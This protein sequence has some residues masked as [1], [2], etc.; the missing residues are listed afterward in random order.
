MTATTRRSRYLHLLLSALLLG[1]LPWQT[2]AATAAPPRPTVTISPHGKTVRAGKSYKF[3]IR[4]RGCRS[5]DVELRMLAGAVGDLD[6]DGE[7]EAPRHVRR[8]HEFYI[9][10]R[11]KRLRHVFDRA[12]VIV[13]PRDMARPDDPV[14]KSFRA[15]KTRI[16]AGETVE[17]SWRAEKA[18]HV[19]IEPGVG[20]RRTRGKITVRPLVTTQYTCTAV[21]QHWH[22]VSRIRI[23]VQPRG[24]H[25][26]LK[27]RVKLLTVTPGRTT[28]GQSVTIQWETERATAIRLVSELGEQYVR[29]SGT[30]RFTPTTGGEHTIMLE[31]SNPLGVDRKEV[32]LRVRDLSR[33]MPK[34]LVFTAAP[35]AVAA[36]APATLTYQTANARRVY[37]VGPRR[38]RLLAGTSGRVLVYPTQS[39]AYKLEAV[40]R[41]GK[42]EATVA[43]RV[44]VAPPP[45]P[46]RIQ[47]FQADPELLFGPGPV[48]LTWRVHGA[49]S[50]SV[51]GL[52]SPNVAAGGMTVQLWRTQEFVLRATNRAG[53]SEAKVRVEL[54][55][56]QPPRIV[57]FSASPQRLH[58]GEK[59]L[60]AWQ[61]TDATRV[62][63][64]G[65]DGRPEQVNPVG[66]REVEFAAHGDHSFRLVATGV[67]GQVEATADVN[68]RPS[69]GVRI[70]RFDATPAAVQPGGTTTL[71]WATERAATVWIENITGVLP[72]SGTK[73]FR[74]MSTT[75]FK[76]IA[77]G[78][79]GIQK[80]ATITV[81]VQ[82]LLARRPVI[83]LFSATP[84]TVIRGQPIV[85]SWRT[86]NATHIKINH[87]SVGNVPAGTRTITA[88]TS[89]DYILTASNRWGTVTAKV[90]II[91]AAPLLADLE[92][93]DIRRG[94]GDRVT[95]TLKNNGAAPVAKD[96]DI[97]VWVSPNKVETLRYSVQYFGQLPPGG[98]LTLTANN[99]IAPANWAI[100]GV[101][102]DKKNE[103][104][105]S[106]E[107]NNFRRIV[108]R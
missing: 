40:N 98:I 25:G 6:D 17:L 23:D 91:V 90:P 68:V 59:A 19:L 82:P 11:H 2:A 41:L 26:R 21:K 22:D 92:V 95:F 7:Y 67:G 58:V 105:E 88:T 20:R 48:R 62:D 53:F 42:V 106:D 78:L 30:A 74:V 15:S 16:R 8:V 104:P 49:S 45:M 50:V 13:I 37:L 72:A 93:I 99:S 4:T 43:V 70:L 52:R 107:R 33:L 18:D 87:L 3:K 89:G 84:T 56:V 94:F 57:I 29:A 79:R 73:A 36:G 86:R 76:L 39:Q 100:A 24:G 46:P 65:P 80:T 61:V 101:T 1:I 69:R 83:D 14:L 85:F 12:R 63:L 27:P 54:R 108:L 75:T 71:T 51:V 28:L 44:L 31:A 9:E 10:V 55:N 64:I 96:F 97:E 47:Y 5:R 34:I 102:L 35:A 103:V 60:L 66:T 81:E 38:R 77:R 32:K